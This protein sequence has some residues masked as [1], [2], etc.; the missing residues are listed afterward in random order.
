MRLSSLAV[1]IVSV[2]LSAATALVISSGAANADGVATTD[3][4]PRLISYNGRVELSGV[5][6]VGQLEMRFRLYDADRGDAPIFSE[7]YTGD[8]AVMV[9]AGDFSVMLG[10]YAAGLQTAITGADALTLGVEV[11]APG[12]VDWIPLAGRQAI[13]PSPYA[14][15]AVQ[16]TDF[17]IARDAFVGRNVDVIG[18]SRVRGNSNVDGTLTA[19]GATTLQSSL[20]VAGG[21]TLS[22][23]TSVGGTLS[24]GSTLSV[25]G[26]VTMANSLTV[27]RNIR[28]GAWTPAYNNWDTFGTGDGGAAI[29]NAGGGDQALMIVGNNSAGSGRRRVKMWDDVTVNGNLAVTG[30]VTANQF[31]G[32]VQANN[33]SLTDNY[34]A[35][36]IG[37]NNSVTVNMTS[38]T[39]SFCFLTNVRS[40][41]DNDEDDI[42]QCAVTVSG[43]TWQLYAYTTSDEAGNTDCQAR[44]FYYR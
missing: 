19:T 4:V 5:P 12:E 27:S 1:P 35:Q 30:N 34:T 37:E 44:C 26:A 2:A 16:G 11:R 20:N 22:G 29:Y 24:V 38:T 39:N 13:T 15:W 43:S 21:S 8:Q 31:S 40:P 6:Y 7:E 9:H 28:A 33:F 17:T 10:Q 42:T 23:N 18:S 36:T 14:M 3:S 41:D 25:T 32:N